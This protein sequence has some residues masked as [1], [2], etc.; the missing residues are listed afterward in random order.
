MWTL[1]CIDTGSFLVDFQRVM[2]NRSDGERVSKE[3]ML[4]ACFDDDDDDDDD[5]D[6][7]EDYVLYSSK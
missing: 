4:S 5:D 2:T 6:E 7:E 1:Q 3:H